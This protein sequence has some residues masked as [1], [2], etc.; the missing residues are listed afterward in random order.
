MKLKKSSALGITLIGFFL[1]VT[2][3]QAIGQDNPADKTSNSTTE[4]KPQENQGAES[5][6]ASA[7]QKP[8][9]N[10]FKLNDSIISDLEERLDEDGEFKL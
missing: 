6:P 10:L 5:P 3:Y 1:S 8:E 4:Q 7:E 9:G 2:A